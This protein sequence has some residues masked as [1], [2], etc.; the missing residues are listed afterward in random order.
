MVANGK[1]E[2]SGRNKK[3]KKDL[4]LV[5][6][7]GQPVISDEAADTFGSDEGEK[8]DQFENDAMAICRALEGIIKQRP[9][10]RLHI[11]LIGKADKEKKQILMHIAPTSQEVLDAAERWQN[12][13]RDN[14]PIITIPLPPDKRGEKTIQAQPCPPYPDRVVRLLSSEWVRGGMDE[15]KLDGPALRHVLDM[16]LRSAGIWEHTAK[17]LLGITIQRIGPL[18]IGIAAS[19]H[20]GEKEQIEKFRPYVRET[21][22]R[23]IALFGIL[24]HVLESRKEMYMKDAPYLVGQVLALADTLHKDYCIVVRKGEMPTSLIGTSLMR[25][26]LDNPTGALA[27]LSERMMEYLRWA[28][29]TQVS[30]EWKDDDRRRIAVNEARKKLRQYEPLSE[31]LA[32]LTLPVESNDLMKAQLLLG[33]LATPPK[34]DQNEKEKEVI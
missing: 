26:A 15:L 31:R 6:C 1:W 11:L 29:T 5:Y 22:L 16:M 4:L 13:V 28:K 14:L 33:F 7:D 10:S 25:R 2:G 8:R 17:N 3:E 21:A 32:S 23:A 12:G 34:E 20:S 18:L 24:L 9:Q 19:L 30:Q 27:D